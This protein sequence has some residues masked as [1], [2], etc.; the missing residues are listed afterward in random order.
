MEKIRELREY[1]AELDATARTMTPEEFAA[2]TKGSIR[3]WGKDK[4][5]KCV[6]VG[7]TDYLWLP[8]GKYDGWETHFPE[9]GVQ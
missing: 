6:T 7:R 5:W 9:N 4:T 8:S 3:M 1:C 2:H